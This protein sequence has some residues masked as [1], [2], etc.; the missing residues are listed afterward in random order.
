M[1]IVLRQHIKNYLKDLV[2][3]TE[4][5]KSEMDNNIFLTNLSHC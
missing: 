5:F 2:I 1:R 3:N 4:P